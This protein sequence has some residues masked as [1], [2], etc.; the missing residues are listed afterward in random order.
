MQVT[1]GYCLATGGTLAL[2]GLSATYKGL[3]SVGVLKSIKIQNANLSSKLDFLKT[4]RAYSGIDVE[5]VFK[6]IKINNKKYF[7]TKHSIE[8][9]SKRKIENKHITDTLLRPLR[10]KDIILDKYNRP[11]QI[12]IG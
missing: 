2:K 9:M 5:T 3:K 6:S 10:I 8:R 7:F 11:S 4:N 12:I 1:N